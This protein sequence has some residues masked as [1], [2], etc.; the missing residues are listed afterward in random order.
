[1]SKHKGV[2]SR[3][4]EG[5]VAIVTGGAS[6]IGAAIVRLFVENGCRVVIA[7]LQKTA[8]MSVAESLGDSACFITLDVADEA[9]W[10]RVADQAVER[11]GRVDILVNAAGL[12]KF[13][14]LLETSLQDFV[15]VMQVNVLGTFLGIKIVGRR[16]VQLGGGSI[17]NISSIE[18]MRGLTELGA[19]VTS[20]W[21]VRG[22][23]KVAALELGRQGVRVNSVH[24]GPVN[25]PMSN[26]QGLPA[27]QMNKVMGHVP[28]QRMGEPIE[29]AEAVLF[30]AGDA[31]TFVNGAEVAVDGGTMAGTYIR[32]PEAE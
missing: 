17:V 27:E 19:Y 21:G 6:G 4:L 3:T 9:Q 20:K 23:T 32:H 30:L 31:A 25:T 22:L 10:E 7:D 12:M 15:S 13:G 16:L 24:P 28:L 8:G 29:I 18:G 14:S 2:S 5:K 26:P 11:F 1:M